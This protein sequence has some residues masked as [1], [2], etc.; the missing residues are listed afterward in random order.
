MLKAALWLA[1]GVAGLFGLGTVVRRR[2]DLHQHDNLELLHPRMRAAARLW[3]ADCTAAG[4]EVRV[5]ETLRSEARQLQL[6]K[7]GASTVTIGY[8]LSG[9]ALDFHV[10]RGPH[11]ALKAFTKPDAGEHAAELSALA[12]VAQLGKARGLRWGGDWRSFKDLYHLE[13]DTHVNAREAFA[14]YQ[15]AGSTSFEVA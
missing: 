10:V 3:L 13:L 7:G 15:R 6:Q 8:H 4:Y 1:A 5:H 11:G 14:R 2:V 9:L 12:A